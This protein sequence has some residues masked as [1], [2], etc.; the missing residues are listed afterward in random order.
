MVLNTIKR[1]DDK[2]KAKRIFNFLSVASGPVTLDAMSDY[3]GWSATGSELPAYESTSFLDVC[4]GLVVAELYNGKHYAQFVHS[5]VREYLIEQGIVRESSAHVEVGRICMAYIN[6]SAFEHK[7]P[8]EK[9]VL[10]GLGPRSGAPERLPS[11][12]GSMGSDSDDEMVDFTELWAAFDRLHPGSDVENI[13][14]TLSLS[15]SQRRIVDQ[16]TQTHPFL[17]YAL[18]NWLYHTRAMKK[19]DPGYQF[20]RSLISLEKAL[21]FDTVPWIK[22]VSGGPIMIDSRRRYI[23]LG[24][25]WANKMKH[26]TLSR[27]LVDWAAEGAKHRPL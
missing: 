18:D 3:L 9:G 7:K 24:N 16:L 27:G 6:Q 20:F 8:D 14:R 2:T 21:L 4:K 5:T 19:Q 22:T 12:A 26:F 13:H 17:P 10:L 25:D 15:S 1:A 11:Y 23:Q